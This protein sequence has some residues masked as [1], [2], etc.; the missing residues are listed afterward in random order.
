MKKK[1]LSL[2]LAAALTLSLLAGCG[3]DTKSDKDNANTIPTT[4]NVSE[5]ETNLPQNKDR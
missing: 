1:I 3:K 4:D 5:N 2:C